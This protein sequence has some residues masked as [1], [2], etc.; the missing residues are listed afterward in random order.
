MLKSLF[1]R[2]KVDVSQLLEQA[3]AAHESGRLDD[4]EDA[5]TRV[6]HAYPGQAEALNLLGA[7]KQSQGKASE[8][9]ELRRQGRLRDQNGQPLEAIELFDRAIAVQSGNVEIRNDRANALFKLGRYAAALA[10]WDQVLERDPE[11]VAAHTGRGNVFHAC[12]EGEAAL[13]AYDRAVQLAP[14]FAGAPYNRALVLTKMRRF[15]E[16]IAAYQWAIG[17]KP[18]FV[19]ALFNCAVLLVDRN[20]HDESLAMFEQLLAVDPEYPNAIGNVALERGTMCHW[21]GLDEVVQRVLEGVNRGKLVSDPLNFMVLCPGAAA[22]Q[23]CAVAEVQAFHPQAAQ[24][25]WNGEIYKHDRI[26]VAYVSADFHEHALAFLVASL[27]ERHDRSRFEVTGVVFG[28]D[29]PS[30]M[31]RRIEA[32][33]EHLLDVRSNTDAEAARMLREREIDIAVDLMGFTSHSRPG[34]FALRPAPVQVNYLGYP[35]T[36]GAPYIDY[37]LGDRFLIPESSRLHYT[38]NV[39]YL[40]NCFQVNDSNRPIAE[41]T[42]SRAELG[43]PEYGFVFCC[44]NNSYK[45]TSEMFSIWMRL[46][47]QVP[48]SVLW[49][50]TGNRWVE[51]NLRRE[52]ERR[53]VDPSRLVFAQRRRAEEYLAQYRQADLFLDTLPFNGGATASDALWAGLP[54]VTCAGEAFASR[55]AGSLLHAVGLPEL[56]TQSLNDYAKLALQLANSPAQLLEIR[57]RLAHNRGTTSLFDTDR[58]CRNLEAAY[59]MM[60]KTTQSGERP[61]T[62]II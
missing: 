7:I 5:C 29:H 9:A 51:P 23:A 46:V 60:W 41:V 59:T 17:I 10:E 19:Q 18:D 31:R 49:L 32:G 33:F 2:R 24:Q 44:M 34:I 36:M 37:I 56:V 14:D 15:D 12:N 47:E 58:F 27:F 43:L 45:I 50:V 62:F 3:V 20:R 22:Q 39:V 61:T 52:A 57:Q 13:A 1:S 38:E 21:D 30:A 28:L 53:G 4:A 40:P 8:A 16:A 35:G 55:M 6:L 26:R 11:Y 25:H 48:G 42:P 54:V